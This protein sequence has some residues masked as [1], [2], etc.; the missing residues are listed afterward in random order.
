M[1]DKKNHATLQLERVADL[2]FQDLLETSDEEIL[3][4]AVEDGMDVE[5]EVERISSII[6][7]A[8]FNNGQAKLAAAKKGFLERKSA[9]RST[10]GSF[11]LQK[12][13]QIIGSLKSNDNL[14][15][16]IT[17]AARNE[18]DLSDSDLNAYL[19][20]LYDLNVIDEEG[21]VL[22]D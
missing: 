22:C 15:R 8:A 20:S 2:I 4:E 19:Q 14:K 1:T 5:K 12:K 16:Q 11:T 18:N 3:A 17:L 13:R 6:S 21:N 9:K 10:F 7:E